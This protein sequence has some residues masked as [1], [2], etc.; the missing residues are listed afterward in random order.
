M[1]GATIRLM[2]KR[3]AVVIR[4]IE[5]QLKGR[6]FYLTRQ[7]RFKISSKAT[8]RPDLVI[9]GKSGKIIKAIIEVEWKTSRKHMVG[10][11]IQADYCMGKENAKPLFCL[12][13][14]DKER[15]TSMSNRIP[16]LKSYCGN[17]YSIK[18][19]NPKVISKALSGIKG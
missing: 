5:E 13:A 3:E 6:G 17:L 18:V 2:N 19:G 11:V 15:C 14:L 12:V 7:E 16:M 1:C 8:Y 9:R 4:R 10:G